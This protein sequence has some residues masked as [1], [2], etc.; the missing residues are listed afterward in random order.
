[1]IR[2]LR[3]SVAPLL[4]LF[5]LE[6]GAII[7]LQALGTSQG[8]Q[9]PWSQFGNWL[10][11]NPLDVLVPPLVRVTALAVAYWMFLST[12]LFVVAQLSRVP[13]AIRATS[14]VTLPSVRRVIDGAMAV[15]IATT[16]VMGTSAHAFAA[17]DPGPSAGDSISTTSVDGRIVLG[18]ATTPVDAGSA[19][20]AN[21]IELAQKDPSTPT[22]TQDTTTTSTTAAPTT[23]SSST[24]SSTAAPTTTSSST[25]TAAPTTTTST[26]AAPETTVAR[27]K[28]P[29]GDGWVGTPRPG[30][31]VAGGAGTQAPTTAAPTTQAPTTQAPTTA[32][33]A[34]P[35]TGLATPSAGQSTGT[36]VLGASEHV[37][38][39]GDNL[40]T[41]SRNALV[42]SGVASPSEAQIRDYWLKV[43]DAN[44]ASLRSGDPH[45]IFPGEIVKLPPR[46]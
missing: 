41:I 21:N 26:S 10:N 12:S 22:P 32:A 30:A 38:V 4:L 36:S 39:R 3:S 16:A 40:W 13:A 7:A 28:L 31:P 25:T 29:A 15:S 11:S 6:V 46:G 5:G 37:V 43:I 19:R 42:D 2:S 17:T 23:T 45:W 44:R 34:S 8:M 1:M 35:E 20:P 33:P 14:M 24:T 18:P 27:P 9:I